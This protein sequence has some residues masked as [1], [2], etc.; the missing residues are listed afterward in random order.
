MAPTSG[1]N[2]IWPHGPGGFLE[3]WSSVKAKDGSLQCQ[4]CVG[5]IA[6]SIAVS[7]EGGGMDYTADGVVSRVDGLGSKTQREIGKSQKRF[8]LFSKLLLPICREHSAISHNVI[9]KTPLRCAQQLVSKLIPEP[10][11]SALIHL[12]LP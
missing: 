12:E 3:H 11:K 9:K 7:M 5:G 10:V 1:P 6:V 2:L 4:V 8:Q